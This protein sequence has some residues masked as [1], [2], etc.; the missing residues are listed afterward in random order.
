MIRR[1]PRSTLFP[2]TTLFRSRVDQADGDVLREVIEGTEIDLLVGGRRARLDR[3]VAHVGAAVADHHHGDRRQDEIPIL[4]GARHLLEE[5]VEISERVGGR[6]PLPETHLDL[7]DVLVVEL[8][9]RV[10]GLRLAVVLASDGRHEEIA[11]LGE[12]AELVHVT[13]EVMGDKREGVVIGGSEG[14]AGVDADEERRPR[15]LV[16]LRLRRRDHDGGTEESGRDQASGER[17]AWAPHSVACFR[18]A[19]CM[20]KVC[21]M[22]QVCVISLASLKGSEKTWRE[23]TR[24]MPKLSAAAAICKTGSTR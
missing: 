9:D 5:D 19:A 12:A 6:E 2:Y 14:S 16:V 4:H 22:C 3:R 8:V 15:R 13:V 11:R 10:E 18:G 1:P 23:A 21:R 7:V 24:T 17:D 20:C